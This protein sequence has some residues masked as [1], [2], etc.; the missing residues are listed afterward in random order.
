[1]YVAI[2]DSIYLFSIAE[3]TALNEQQIKPCVPSEILGR[4][5]LGIDTAFAMLY[6]PPT[7]HL[8]VLVQP[9]V[10]VLMV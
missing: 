1:L 3:K 8:G 4:R 5:S 10:H 2:E 6:Y 9:N 7:H